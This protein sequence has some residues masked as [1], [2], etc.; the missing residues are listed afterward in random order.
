MPHTLDQIL[1]SLQSLGAWSYWLLALFAMLEAIVLTGIVAPGALAVIAGG[2]LVQRGV[3]DFFDLA[4]FVLAGTVAGS[5]I[6][7]RLGRMAGAGMAGR[8]GGGRHAARAADLLKRYGGFAMVLGRFLGPLSAFVPFSAAMA[9]MA[10][11]R[12]TAWNVASGVPYALILPALGYVFGTA[13]GHLGAAAPRIAL[14]TVAV[15]AIL[16]LLWVVFARLRG[17][18]PMALGLLRALAR[19]AASHPRVR[20]LTARHPRVTGFVARRFDASRA[21]GLTATVLAALFV[22]IFGLYLDSVFDF[23]HNSAVTTAD[24]RLANLIYA[25]RDSR[26]VYFFA[27]VTAFGNWKS[28]GALL[29][30][31]VAALALARRWGLLTS[32]LVTVAGNQI[33][34]AAMKV[35]F[36]RP[37]SVLG[38]FAES[39]HSFPSGHAASSVAIWGLLFYLAW[40][41]RLVSGLVAGLAAITVAFLLGLSRIYLVE[42]YLS[43]V[44]NGWLV[45]GLWLLIGISITEWRH[46]PRP[47]GA[48]LRRR[49]GAVAVALGMA[50]AVAAAGISAP[51]L[52]PAPEITDSTVQDP[53][54]LAAAGA[55][56]RQVSTVTGEPLAGIDLLVVA[57]GA[58]EL[59]QAMAGAGWPRAAALGPTLLARAFWADWRD[60]AQPKGLVVPEFWDNR[61]DDLA[62]ERAEGGVEARAWDSRRVTPGGARVYVVSV[63]PPGG[64]DTPQGAASMALEVLLRDLEAAGARPLPSPAKDSLPV[65]RL[66]A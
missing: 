54:S 12:F 6:S 35:A 60:A 23:L 49:A 5:E 37:R 45:G 42:H 26:L 47:P 58:A 3:L 9:G 31:V 30:G 56:P 25:F 43:D 20:A 33:T 7:F 11:R 36:G 19:T 50:G 40:R 17:A 8:F 10:H 52:N 24:T 65:L 61:P 48:P 62:F 46:A 44:L 34:V 2:I 4:W 51:A 64:Q 57:P 13:L 38:Y 15:L 16:A 63:T 1:P 22:Y 29:V 18:L 27:W 14:F 28:V 41:T 55:L 59:E 53:V 39:S 21:S 66:G 32:L